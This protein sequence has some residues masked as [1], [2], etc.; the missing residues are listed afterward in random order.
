MV[1]RCRGGLQFSSQRV[2]SRS[3]ADLIGTCLHAVKCR[4]RADVECRAYRPQKD[5][6]MYIVMRE[7]V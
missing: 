5:L 7:I 3:V 4:R 1:I 2:S 6:N